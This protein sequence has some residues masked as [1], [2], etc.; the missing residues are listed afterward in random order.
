M[1]HA[2]NRPAA[3]IPSGDDWEIPENPNDSWI[4]PGL[5]VGYHYG[6]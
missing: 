3:I 1:S 6:G 2:K 5:T 4:T